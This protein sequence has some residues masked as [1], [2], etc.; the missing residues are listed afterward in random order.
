MNNIN[1][2]KKSDIWKIQLTLA[3][4]FISSEDTDED[5]LMHSTNDTPQI[6]INDKV[7]KVM[8][9]RFESI[10]YKYQTGLE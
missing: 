8:K 7:E 5:R 2:L 4:N 6:M 1:N 10:L 3:I 9:E